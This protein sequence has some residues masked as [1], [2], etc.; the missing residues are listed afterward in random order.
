MASDAFDPKVIV[1]FVAGAELPPVPAELEGLPPLELLPQAARRA[2]TLRAAAP[3]K[4]VRRPSC[5][6]ATDV[7]TR[8]ARYSASDCGRAMVP[9]L[10]L[11]SVN[12]SGGQHNPP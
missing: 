11:N 5:V 10:A 4:S 9:P 12:T 1:P 3:L 2:G 8:L 6:A 7:G